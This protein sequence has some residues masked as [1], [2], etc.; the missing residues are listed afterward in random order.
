MKS[1]IYYRHASHKARIRART[2]TTPHTRAIQNINTDDARVTERE[3][4][5]ENVPNREETVF[6]SHGGGSVVV[7][8][9]A[10]A[11]LHC[12][13]PLFG[14]TYKISKYASLA[15]LWVSGGTADGVVLARRRCLNEEG[16]FYNLFATKLFL[17]F[18]LTILSG[19]FFRR[20]FIFPSCENC[21][22]ALTVLQQA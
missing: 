6:F 5:G 15:S 2:M 8:E 21:Q 20:F 9:N 18:L 1:I 11:P 3:D 14:K 12:S 19:F 7:R 10:W 17:F 4:E 16:F 22:L 13:R